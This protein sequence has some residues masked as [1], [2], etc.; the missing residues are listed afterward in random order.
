MKAFASLFL[1]M[2]AAIVAV[3][4]SVQPTPAPR[5]EKR[6]GFDPNNLSQYTN[7]AALSSLSDYISSQ[8]GALESISL[9]GGQSS[10]LASQKSEAYSYLSVA[11]SLLA[12]GG[13]SN[14][15]AAS[16]LASI[17]ATA[18]DALASAS[19]A[20]SSLASAASVSASS[21]TRSGSSNAAVGSY[22]SSYLVGMVGC[23]FVAA[24]AGAFAL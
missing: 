2:L 11:S 4:A 13:V 20:G 8:F 9:G 15:N 12:N 17:T 21:T 16:I 10:Y 19:K 22:T 24:L 6:Q 1:V 23:T 5:I 3:Q 14:S 18:S 7:P